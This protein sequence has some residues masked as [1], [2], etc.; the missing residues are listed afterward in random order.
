[1][2]GISHVRRIPELSRMFVRISV[3]IKSLE[4]NNLINF[5]FKYQNVFGNDFEIDLS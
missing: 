1:M 4:Q 3:F 5:H 2:Y